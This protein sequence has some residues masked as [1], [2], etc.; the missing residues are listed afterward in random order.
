MRYGLEGSLQDNIAFALIVPPFYMYKLMLAYCN[1][2]WDQMENA[3]LFCTCFSAHMFVID[4]CIAAQCYDPKKVFLSLG[5]V[6][7]A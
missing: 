4:L 7:L 5:Q 1:R 3:L 2:I 6:L